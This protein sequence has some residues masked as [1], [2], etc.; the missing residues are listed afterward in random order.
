MTKKGDFR[1]VE[2][3]RALQRALWAFHKPNS[4]SGISDMISI[5]VHILSTYRT[6]LL[7]L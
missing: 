3:R 4:K 7:K 2:E 6:F 5:L 1:W